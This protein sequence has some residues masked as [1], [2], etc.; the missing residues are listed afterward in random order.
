M[1]IVIVA[2]A[3]MTAQANLKETLPQMTTITGSFAVKMLP[4]PEGPTEFVRLWLDKTFQG[5]LEGTSKV[6]MLASNGGDQASGGYVAL[7]RFTG[8]VEGKQ[9]SFCLQ[10]SGIMKPGL[11]EIQVRVTPGS[12]TGELLGIEGTLEIRKEGKLH[13]Y[14]MQYRL[15]TVITKEQ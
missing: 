11:M 10:H 3:L 1:P 14:T 7:E 8:K 12:G 15:A 4:P 13:F 2:L 9:G 5:G 6:E